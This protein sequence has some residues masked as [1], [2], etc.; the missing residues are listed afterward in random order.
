[1]KNTDGGKAFSHKESEYF[2]SLMEIMK[3]IGDIDW[4]GKSYNVDNYTILAK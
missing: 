1:M 4:A 2:Y 3:S